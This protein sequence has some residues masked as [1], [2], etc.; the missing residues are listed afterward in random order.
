[1][2]RHLFPLMAYAGLLALVSACQRGGDVDPVVAEMARS[3]GAPKTTSDL[4]LKAARGEGRILVLEAEMPADI[5]SLVGARDVAAS[6][7]HGI[8]ANPRSATF[9]SDG[10]TLRVE[11]SVPGRG[12]TSA[13]VDRC[14][15][16]P[17]GQG[18]NVESYAQLYRRMEGR[19]LGDGSTITATR[20]EGQTLVLVMNGR[21]GWRSGMTPATIAQ[22]FLAE[23]C[24]PASGNAFFGGGRALRIDTTEDGARL[25]RGETVTACPARPA[26]Q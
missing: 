6:F 18:V 25:V 3:I 13:T 2:I 26:T 24:D 12:V 9:F 16:G 14:P 23:F 1:M 11:L 19:D 10:R 15:P 8:C 20:V 17:V 21:R 7:A 4:S 22:Q 5:A